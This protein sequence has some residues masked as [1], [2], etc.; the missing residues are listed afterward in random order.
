MSEEFKVPELTDDPTPDERAEYVIMRLEQFIRDG[1]T[2]DE[3]MSFKIWQAMAKTEIAI[4]V[5]EAELG[6]QKEE[7]VTRRLL[8]TFAAALVTVGF[9]GTAVSMHKIGYLAGAIVVTLSGLVL[10]GVA[11]EWRFRKWRQV[12]QANKRRKALARIER[13][14]RR[15]KRLE[16]D[17]EKEEK[18]LKKKVK[19]AAK[20]A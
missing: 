4:A 3:G 10:L 9:W 6:Q 20:V 14:N 19:E 12:R 17:L 5:A 15:I 18:K 8:F 16:G 1:R 13:I 2:L 11:G 7:S